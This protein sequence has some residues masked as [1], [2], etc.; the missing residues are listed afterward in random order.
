M[1]VMKTPPIVKK[2]EKMSQDKRDNLL[3]VHGMSGYFEY[4]YPH[5]VSSRGTF[6]VQQQRNLMSEELTRTLNQKLKESGFRP[7]Y[8]KGI[9][10][11]DDLYPELGSR[12]MSDVDIYLQ[13]VDF[14]E[15]SSLMKSWGYLEV[16]DKRWVA[17]E[18]KRE[19]LLKNTYGEFCFE[20]HN[21][22]FWHRQD[23]NISFLSHDLPRIGHEEAFVYICGH[24]AFMHSCQKMYWLWDIYLYLKTYGDKLDHQ[25]IGMLA[26]HFGFKR[27]IKYCLKLVS[28]AFNFE[29]SLFTKSFI[30]VF[31]S[32]YF[33]D[34]QRSI[35]YLYLKY[36]LKDHFSDQWKYHWS[37]LS[38]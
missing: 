7:A 21:K 28:V 5:L 24:F 25:K 29:Y 19:Y 33:S 30:P 17:N 4:F 35:S 34:H 14:K 9:T 3:Q 38:K 23:P 6:K 18:H 36:F 20:F 12:F 1:K 10:F 15:L 2:I 11:F 8:L 26:D 32:V 13:G 22:L 31:D 27:S 16:S 37:Y